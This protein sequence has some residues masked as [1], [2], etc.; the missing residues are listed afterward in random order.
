MTSSGVLEDD[1]V[2]VR[3]VERDLA[4]LD[5]SG[6]D[7]LA[8]RDRLDRDDDV[9]LLQGALAGLLLG[10]VDQVE[11]RAAGREGEEDA[12]DD[13]RLASLRGVPVFHLHGVLPPRAPD[14]RA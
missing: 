8:G 10:L 12:D 9:G 1:R 5:V 13:D 6:L 3:R 7:R 4:D 2:R 14:R 11:R